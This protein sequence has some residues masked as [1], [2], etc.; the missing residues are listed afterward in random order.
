MVNH[1]IK[2]ELKKFMETND[3]NTIIIEDFNTPLTALDRSTR[4]QRL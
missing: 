4:K 2:E 3:N 1:E